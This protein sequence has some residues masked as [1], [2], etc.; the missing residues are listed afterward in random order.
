M[1]LSSQNWR[2]MK[3]RKTKCK[4]LQFQYIYQV[5]RPRGRGGGGQED[6][7]RGHHGERRE[8]SRGNGKILKQCISCFYN[9]DLYVCI[10]V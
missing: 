1:C 6:G 4:N 5:K 7:G 8:P 3:I 10:P 9:Y 2:P